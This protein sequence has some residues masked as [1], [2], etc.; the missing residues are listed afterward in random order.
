MSKLIFLTVITVSVFFASCGGPVNPQVF[1]NTTIKIFEEANKTLSEFDSKIT[2]GIRAN[3]LAS[4]AVAADSALARVDV[5]I[6][7]MKDLKSPPNGVKYKESVSKFLET[8]KAVAEIGK[9]YSALGEAYTRAELDAVE[10]EYSDKK[11][12]LSED[13][14]NVANM[15]IQFAKAVRAR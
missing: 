15:Q 1:N 10:K 5:Q 3:D 2:S 12:E 6:N 4:I 8:T 14:K 9:K 13:L 11:K 7:K